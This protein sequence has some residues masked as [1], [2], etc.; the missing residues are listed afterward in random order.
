DD[1]LATVRALEEISTRNSRAGLRIDPCPFARALFFDDNLNSILDD[2]ERHCESGVD[3]QIPG[4]LDLV[5]RPLKEVEATL[6]DRSRALLQEL[7]S[8]PISYYIQTARCD[9]EAALI[10]IRHASRPWFP[11]E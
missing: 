2:F 11:S 1:Q 10:W 9:L 6:F 8:R 5:S 4:F 3:Q 7:Q